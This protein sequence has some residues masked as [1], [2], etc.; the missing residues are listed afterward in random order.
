VKECLDGLASVSLVSAPGACGYTNPAHPLVQM[1]KKVV[2][3]AHIQVSDWS[4]D[5]CFFT[6][7]HI[8]TIV[9]GPGNK[10][11]MH[12]PNEYCMEKNIAQCVVYYGKIV[13]RFA[14][15]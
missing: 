7:A 2:M 1:A 4:S 3:K 11:C 9:F 15:A 5:L 13:E 14:L 10:A 6:K 8:P 12:K